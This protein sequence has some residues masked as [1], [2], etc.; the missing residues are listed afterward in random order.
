MEIDTKLENEGRR[1]SQ[2][3]F[4][5][6]DGDSYYFGRERKGRRDHERG[7]RQGRSERSNERRHRR[8]KTDE[9]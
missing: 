3:E 7:R 6:E 8:N 2:H 1:D 4:S 9:R 5:H